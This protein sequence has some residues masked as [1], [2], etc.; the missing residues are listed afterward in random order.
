MGKP[1]AI[2]VRDY[3]DPNLPGTSPQYFTVA[4]S[5]TAIKSEKLRD[6]FFARFDFDRL[7]SLLGK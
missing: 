4:F 7:V 5:W 3:F 6:D 2:Y 1:L